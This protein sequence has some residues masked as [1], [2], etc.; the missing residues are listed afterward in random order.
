MKSM[1]STQHATTSW[2]WLCNLDAAFPDHEARSTKLIWKPQNYI[3]IEG[4]PALTLLKLID[5]LED[6]DDVQNVYHS[7]EID[8]ATLEAAE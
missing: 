6:L 4:D 7:G 3:E 5:A 1:S 8:E 2:K